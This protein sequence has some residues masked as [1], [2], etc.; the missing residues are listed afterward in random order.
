MQF[1]PGLLMGICL[2]RRCQGSDG[3]AGRNSNGIK[4]KPIPDV[5]GKYIHPPAF[6][7]FRLADKDEK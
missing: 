7:E 5:F 3:R 1:L 6:F 4:G 2:I